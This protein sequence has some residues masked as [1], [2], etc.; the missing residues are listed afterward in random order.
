MNSHSFVSWQARDR[1]WV[2]R[3]VKDLRRF[4]AEVWWSGESLSQSGLWI[5]EVSAR[6]ETAT[7]FIPL[8]TPE[9]FESMHCWREVQAAV[10][11]EQ[12]RRKFGFILPLLL[13]Q[14]NLPVLLAIPPPLDF[15]NASEYAVRLAELARRIGPPAA[16]RFSI[17]LNPLS[18]VATEAI[19]PPEARQAWTSLYPRHQRFVHPLT[20][21]G[22]KEACPKCHSLLHGAMILREQTGDGGNIME[23]EPGLCCPQCHSGYFRE[24]LLLWWRPWHLV[25]SLSS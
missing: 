13:R 2:E 21:V 16:L 24:G 8:F 25:Q 4:G 7:Y 18:A 5:P 19:V 1:D 17:E 6:L 3:L 15:T 14:V 10:L 12:R 9:F 20:L 11:V 22:G 23:A